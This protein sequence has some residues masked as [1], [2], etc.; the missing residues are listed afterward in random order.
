MTL[1]NRNLRV[2]RCYSKKHPILKDARQE[3]FEL[4]AGIRNTDMLAN[5][6][7]HGISFNDN[8]LK[9]TRG[10]ESDYALPI[11]RYIEYLTK[12]QVL[13][14]LTD[15]FEPSWGKK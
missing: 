12:T 10:L 14:P 6:I 4:L 5:L 1:I 7:I 2:R 11:F 3:W 9:F 8:Y 13:K 15:S